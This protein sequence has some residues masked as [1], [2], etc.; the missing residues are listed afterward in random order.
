MSPPPAGDISRLSPE[1][2]AKFAHFITGELGIKMPQSK[3]SM[4]QS[5]LL[6]RV[7][8]LG[9]DSVERYSRY[10]FESE[11]AADERAHLI[12][13]ITTN[14]TDFFREAQHFRYLI[15]AVLPQYHDDRLRVWS[16]GCSSGEEPYT[17]AM[18]LSD[19][20]RV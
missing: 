5:R 8:E 4:V 12:N 18:I 14:K 15:D 7:R 6:R 3:I 1:S 19:Y 17:L 13:A 16:A 20:A 10:F 2:F 11:H 9:F